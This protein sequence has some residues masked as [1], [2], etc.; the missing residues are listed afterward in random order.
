MLLSPG[1]G[2]ITIAILLLGGI[3]LIALGVI[4]EYI[5]RIYDEV[6]HRPL[7]IV[8]DERNSPSEAVSVT[9]IAGPAHSV[10]VVRSACPQEHPSASAEP[11]APTAASP[12]GV[13]F[14]PAIDFPAPPRAP[15]IRR[16]V[17]RT[18]RAGG[19][20]PAESR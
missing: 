16:V 20:P 9:G 11:P 8:A 19:H 2:S 4:G 10:P 1:F 12:D 7:Y 18:L 3:K 14:H 17:G 13:C 6:K 5:G 15:M